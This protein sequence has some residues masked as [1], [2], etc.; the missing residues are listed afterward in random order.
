[1]DR[2]KGKR[3]LITGGT[4]GIGLETARLFI[5]EGARVAV[6][7]KN[8]D[9]LEAARKT[10]GQDALVFASDAGDA[11]SQQALADALGQTL[12]GLDVVFLN[13]GIV[14]MRPLGYA[15]PLLI[16]AGSLMLLGHAHSSLGISEQL[17]SLINMQH[18]IIGSFGLIAGTTRWLQVRGL[19]G[20]A[21]FRYVWPSAIV[22]LGLFM[23]FF[24]RELVPL[25]SS[26]AFR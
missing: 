23:A 25:S 15:L 16:I 12:G 26:L 5:A 11:A 13:A 24:Y 4:S 20:R 14:E 21:A 19:P 22:L 6:T 3:A 2:L 7:G 9:T 18:A 17:S 10:L 8:P 1:M